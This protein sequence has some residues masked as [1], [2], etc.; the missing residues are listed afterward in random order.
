MRW[1]IYLENFQNRVAKYIYLL[2]NIIIKEKEIPRRV[3][4]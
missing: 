1:Q 2:Y 4:R 3:K